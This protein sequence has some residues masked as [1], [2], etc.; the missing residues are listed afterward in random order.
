MLEQSTVELGESSAVS[1]K[2]SPYF[3][4]AQVIP[5]SYDNSETALLVQR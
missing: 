5:H 2:T 4:T 3:E 1:E